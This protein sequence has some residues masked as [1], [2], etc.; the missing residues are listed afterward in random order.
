MS[1][2]A[3]AIILG[4]ILLLSAGCGLKKQSGSVNNAVSDMQKVSSGNQGVTKNEARDVSSGEQ[5]GRK[6]T[7]NYEIYV[8]VEDLKILSRDIQDKARTMGGYIQNE[9][10][11]EYG[12]SITVRIPQQEA[13]KFVEYI[14]KTYEVKNKKSRTEDITQAYTDNDARLKNLK[15]QEAQILEILKKANRVEDILKVQEE[16]YKLRGEIESLEA[17]K[18][19]WDRQIEYVTILI[20]AN[21]KEIIKEN[22]IS[23]IKGSDFFKAISRGVVNSAI[24]L[25]VGVQRLIIFIAANII[26]MIILGFAAWYIYRKYFKNKNVV[27]ICKN[28]DPNDKE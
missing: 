23:I 1:K 12:C 18:K 22:K 20:S 8:V 14:D 6:I 11:N 25:I 17:M 24:Y 26:W 28:R 10:I 3:L 2:K 16:L 4:I 15:A 13:E 27:S 21:K 19:M 5:N 7:Q 9:D